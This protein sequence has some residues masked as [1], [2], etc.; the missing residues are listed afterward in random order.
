M[1]LG[2][3]SKCFLPGHTTRH[4]LTA[5]ILRQHPARS[6]AFLIQPLPQ[7]VLCLFFLCVFV[8]LRP[9][10]LISLSTHL[11]AL[12]L[13]PKQ[14]FLTP[15]CA[16]N[17][18]SNLMRALLSKCT[19]Q[20]YAH[21]SSHTIQH[22]HRPLILWSSEDSPVRLHVPTAASQARPVAGVARFVVCEPMSLF[23]EGRKYCLCCSV[24]HLSW[25]Q[26]S[27]YGAKAGI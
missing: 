22:M 20:R 25:L 3:K 21:R 8:P 10:P 27:L 18:L 1:C 17:S 19:L 4:P 2:P 7:V 15:F 23:S 5:T 13:I 16:L 6:P 11:L 12:F 24:I 9:L 14:W 26:G